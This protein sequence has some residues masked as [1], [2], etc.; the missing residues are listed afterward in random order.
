MKKIGFRLSLLVIMLSCFWV[1]IVP[2]TVG[3]VEVPLSTGDSRLN[4]QF[5]MIDI[6]TEQDL[7]RIEYDLKSLSIDDL[8]LV[9]SNVQSLYEDR[10]INGNGALKVAWLAAAQVARLSGYPL[11]ATLVEY[12]VWDRDYFEVNGQFAIAIKQTDVYKQLLRG[13]NTGSGSFEKNDNSDLYYSIHAF[14]YC[15]AAS[16]QGVRAWITDVYDFQWKPS[17]ERLFSTIVNNWGYLS[18][19]MGVLQPINVTITIDA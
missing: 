1:S 2:L 7:K 4:R 8:Q 9:I 3:A 11:S 10:V 18:Q 16:S 19:N 14:D 13:S 15:V 12:S 17:Y 5:E 6:D